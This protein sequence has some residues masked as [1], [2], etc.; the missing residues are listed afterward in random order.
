MIE[1]HNKTPSSRRNQA[2]LIALGA[3][4]GLVINHFVFDNAGIGL[5]AGAS[6]GLANAGL[7][8]TR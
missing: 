2:P 3:G 6:L 1:S 5:V 7:K 4:P 8:R